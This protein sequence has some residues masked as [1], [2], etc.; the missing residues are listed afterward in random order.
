M[1]HPALLWAALNRRFAENPGMRQRLFGRA[2]R[3]VTDG[4]SSILDALPSG[5][6]KEWEKDAREE[7][8]RARRQGAAVLTLQ[9][10]SYPPLL[11][12]SSDPPLVLYVWGDLRPED[13][14]AV[15]VVGSRRATPLGLQVA[16]DLGRGLAAAGFTVVSG[17]ARGIDAASHRGALEGGGRTIAVLGSGLDRIYPVEHRSLAKSI[18]ARG[19]VVTEFPFGSAPL[20]RNFPERNRIIASLTWGT[21]VVEAAR[22]SGSLITADLA[23]DEGRAV[24]AVPGSVD[25]PN[26][27]GT[28]ELLRSGALLCRGAADVLEDLAP[29]IVEA[30]GSIARW[31][32]PQEPLP[33]LGPVGTEARAAR[34]AAAD[35]ASAE[36]RV[37]D[38]IPR[39]RGIGIERLGEACA[40]APG[41]LLATLLELELKGLV[42]QLPGRRFQATA[43]K[44]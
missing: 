23:A 3:G 26:A 22:G 2:G 29:Q 8:D 44:I 19:A 1:E 37:L 39:T 18:V 35:L 41:A 28:N 5:L 15:A 9:D 12:A 43:C 24:Y 34:E 6:P 36:K 4:P 14:L 42:R 40:M 13:V 7:L 38:Q 25:E 21:V 11:R 27:L 32:S 30:A 33:G 16:G 31:R 20:R 17:L 10:E